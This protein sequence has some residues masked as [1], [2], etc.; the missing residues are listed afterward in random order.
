M[1]DIGLLMEDDA[2]A[3]KTVERAME[4]FEV[5]IEALQDAVGKLR[6]EYETGEKAVMSDL[7]VMNAA[8]THAMKMEAAAR[9]A[10]SKHLTIATAGVELDLDAAREEI[11]LR[12]ACLRSAGDD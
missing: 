11:G 8:F 4:A 9:D 3:A 1:T 7:K 6:A 10:A 2:R 12:L 5:T